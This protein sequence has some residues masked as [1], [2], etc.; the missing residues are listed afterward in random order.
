VD[1]RA[2][3]EELTVAAAVSMA[4]NSGSIV[5]AGSLPVS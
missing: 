2:W 1:G 4:E 5:D 3:I